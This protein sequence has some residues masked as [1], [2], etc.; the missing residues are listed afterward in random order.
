MLTKT[1]G[2]RR[3]LL[4]L[5]LF[6]FAPCN[7]VND[8]NRLAW[9]LALNLEN[10]LAQAQALGPVH[11]CVYVLRRLLAAANTFFASCTCILAMIPLRHTIW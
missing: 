1:S 4:L 5:S 9:F 10:V 8:Y 2:P 3:S 7:R 11:V 6:Y